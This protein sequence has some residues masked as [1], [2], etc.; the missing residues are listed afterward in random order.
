MLIVSKFHDYYDTAIG[1]GVDKTVVYERTPRVWLRRKKQWE[2]NPLQLPAYVN[3]YHY[4][5]GWDYGD[6]HYSV[7][8]GDSIRRQGRRLYYHETHAGFHLIGFCGEVW[9]VLFVETPQ[10]DQ[11]PAEWEKTRYRVC[12]TV[13]EALK[14]RAEYDIHDWSFK[15]KRLRQFFNLED[16]SIRQQEERFIRHKCPVF[17]S[18]YRRLILNPCLK[19]AQFYRIKDPYTAFQDIYMYISGVLGTVSKETVEISDKDMRDKK[20]FDE[21]SFKKLPSKKRTRR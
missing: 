15:E 8:Y 11:T 14:L 4:L 7:S 13:E 17:M 1:Y 2:E 18:T 16:V 9:P 20:G 12:Y 6:L 10:G 19:P 5:G 21:W 3:T